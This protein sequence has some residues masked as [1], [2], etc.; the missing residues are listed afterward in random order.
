MEEGHSTYTKEGGLKTLVFESFVFECFVIK[1]A[2]EILLFQVSQIIGFTDFTK[3][4]GFTSV[5]GIEELKDVTNIAEVNDVTVIEG[6][7]TEKAQ[8]QTTNA[9]QT[10][11]LFEGI[12]S[13]FKMVFQLWLFERRGGGERGSSTRAKVKARAK[14][15]EVHPEGGGDSVTSS[16]NVLPQL[17][18]V[19]V[20]EP[21]YL[22][23]RKRHRR[24]YWIYDLGDT[25]L[26]CIDKFIIAKVFQHVRDLL[27]RTCRDHPDAP[28]NEFRSA[29]GG[30]GV[31]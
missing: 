6:P 21:H 1:K 7:R 9:G 14:A 15:I 2:C 19:H 30:S 23:D 31:L 5:Q 25:G 4:S 17:L 22:H 28:P 16:T 27:I 8:V 11:N 13:L 18:N 10:E 3:V 20:L 26:S 12:P 29:L 24:S